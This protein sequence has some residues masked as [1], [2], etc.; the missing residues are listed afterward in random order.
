[1]NR[2]ILAATICLFSI[3]VFAQN[4]IHVRPSND[5]EL[6][7]DTARNWK[8][9]DWITLHP[10][11]SDIRTTHLKILYSKTGM[12]FLFKNDDMVITST[13]KND[14]D[15]LWLEDVAEIFLWPDTSVTNY[16]EYEISPHNKELV[17]LI[18]NIN[19]KHSGWHPWQYSGKRRI[20][21]NTK[22]IPGRCWYAE[23]FIPYRL[24]YP[25]VHES[26]TPSKVWRAN[27]YRSDRD[28]KITREW[29]W[30]TTARSFHE[31]KRFGYLLFR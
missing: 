20:K 28:N 22:I 5:F 23:V 24:L 12:Y 18:V 4:V 31:Y 10:D 26:P 25:M 9:A 11:S 19:G 3:S 16:L 29:S 6:S 17:M 15:S 8:N 14:F 7:F 13:M 27:F 30:K 2:F 21:H 1:M